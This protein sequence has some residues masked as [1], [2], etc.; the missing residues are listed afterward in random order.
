MYT[1]GDARASDRKN[2]ETKTKIKRKPHA[3]HIMPGREN[4]TS[5]NITLLDLLIHAFVHR[6]PA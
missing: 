3:N 1:A 4:D 6:V 2:G 5:Y